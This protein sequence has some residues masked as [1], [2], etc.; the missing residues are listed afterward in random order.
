MSLSLSM[1]FVMICVINYENMMLDGHFEANYGYLDVHLNE[2][3][4]GFS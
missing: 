3:E 2:Q 1:Y 4:L